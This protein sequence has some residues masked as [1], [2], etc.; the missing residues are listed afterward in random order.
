MAHSM[1]SRHMRRRA[2]SRSSG[3]SI[4]L[5]GC[6]LS[7]MVRKAASYGSSPWHTTCDWALRGELPASSGALI[8]FGSLNAKSKAVL[9]ISREFV[10]DLGKAEYRPDLVHHI[11]GI[12]NKIADML[13]RRLRPGK[14]CSLPIELSGALHV[15][16]ENRP[17]SWWRAAAGQP[18][19][20]PTADER[21]DSL[22]HPRQ[23]TPKRARL[24]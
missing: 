11:P 19:V 16:P 2:V 17:K 20:K 7:C 13:L 15:E 4:L 14:S 3:S 8:V 6:Y 10:L 22:Q 23:G 18:P 24:S 5:P 12:S 9:K 1:R 21:V